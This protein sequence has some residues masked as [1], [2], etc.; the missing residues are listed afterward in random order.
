MT[1]ESGG[2]S[3]S[4]RTAG[5]IDQ[6]VREIGVPLFR[7]AFRI[8]DSGADAEDAVQNAWVRGWRRVASLRTWNEQRAFMIRV[9]VNEA[10]QLIR[11]R[12][13]K[14]ECLGVEGEERAH[15][16]EDIEQRMEAK[17]KL[18]LAWQAIDRLPE[19]CREVMALHTAG[20]EY[21]EV[22]EMLGI[23]VSTVR[24]HISNARKHLRQV[25]P[26]VW[27]GKPE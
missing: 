21:G 18:R 24:S 2:L 25:P 17:E 16:S 23:H 1:S 10:R 20:Y 8:L 6:L 11:R 13:R 27:E 5:D 9:V 12:Y 26:G 22:A 7:V 15:T 14:Q 4:A 3:A 19:G